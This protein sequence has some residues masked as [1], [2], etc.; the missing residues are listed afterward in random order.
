M[1]PMGDPLFR[2]QSE[3][4]GIDSSRIKRGRIPGPEKG[5]NGVLRMMFDYGMVI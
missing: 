5:R 3:R 1:V 4:F 2:E